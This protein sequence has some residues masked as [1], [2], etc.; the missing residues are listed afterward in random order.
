MTLQ[1]IMD[2]G[3]ACVEF[4]VR[5][6]DCEDIDIVDKKTGAMRKWNKR[7]LAVELGR[8][9]RQA[10]FFIE[11]RTQEEKD[12]LVGQVKK[13]MRCRAVIDSM[14]MEKGNVSMHGNAMGFVILEPGK[15]HK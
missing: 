7:I 9:G 11:G 1:E 5:G 14:F 8:V 10:K 15:D 2:A 3:E 6:F 4:E 13:G 12:A